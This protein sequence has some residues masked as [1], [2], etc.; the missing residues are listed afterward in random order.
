MS[1]K[2]VEDYLKSIY[3]LSKNGTTVNTTEIS[4]TLKVAP[5]SVTEML[6]KLSEN[7]YV[8]YSPYHGSTLTEKGFQEAQ[9][10]ARK[11]RLLEKF[12]SDV[13]HI[14]TDQVHVQACEM[15]HT[16]SDEAEESLMPLPQTPRQVSRRRQD[17]TRLQPALCFM[18]RVH[19]T[20]QQRS[21]RGWET[22]RKFDFD[23][24]TQNG[25]FGKNLVHQRRTP[26][27]AEASGYGVDAWNLHKRCP[28]CS[29]RRSRGGLRPRLKS[30]VGAGHRR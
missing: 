30:R 17:H 25:C 20:A 8:N 16:L 19:P 15:E 22:T 7:G 12:L 5:A 18:R 29:A 2:S 26:S 13:L 24:H 23:L 4:R 1:Q 11:H 6:K 27:S 9:K 3:D 28:G 10:I 14:K 21:R